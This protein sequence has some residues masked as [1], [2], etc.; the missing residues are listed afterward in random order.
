M[1]G[2]DPVGP[3]PVGFLAE[4]QEDRRVAA[5]W[6]LG[7]G[8]LACPRCD[9]PV[10]LAEAPVAPSDALACPFCDHSAPARDFLSLSEPS[11][12]THVEVRI[13]QRVRRFSHGGGAFRR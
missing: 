4:T 6:R 3:Q 7:A 13:V 11:R 10:A 1:D 8:T 2:A 12:P 9:A 5:T